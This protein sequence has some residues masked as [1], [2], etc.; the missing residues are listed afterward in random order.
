M[1][2]I[3]SDNIPSIGELAMII[4]L[5]EHFNSHSLM[6]RES[7]HEIAEIIAQQPYNVEITIDFC[8][9]KFA[10]RSFLNQLLSDVYYRKNIAIV[11]PNNTIKEMMKISF[12]PPSS[13][14]LI[15]A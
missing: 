4:K 15:T 6:Y 7:A 10:T 8:E 5:Y 13:D 1:T 2:Q 9:I 11:N 14:S 12:K 3:V